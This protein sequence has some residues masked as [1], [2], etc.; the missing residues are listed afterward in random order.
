MSTLDDLNLENKVTLNNGEIHKFLG[1]TK[2]VESI[3]QIIDKFDEFKSS[4]T[5]VSSNK[6][7]IDDMKN[8]KNTVNTEID[9]LHS[10]TLIAYK[11]YAYTDASTS[12]SPF[13]K[14]GVYGPSS[15]SG[16]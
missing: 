4:L 5:A 7:M 16:T 11:S 15:T 13:Y 8:S 12:D 2:L 1:M 10:S 14:D 3:S 6:S 9:S